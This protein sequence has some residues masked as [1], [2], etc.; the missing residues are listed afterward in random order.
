MNPGRKALTLVHESSHFW[1]SGLSEDFKYGEEGC[2]Q[3]AKDNPDKA[4]ANADNIKFFARN[5]EGLE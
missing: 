2:K 1:D 3:L 5:E 4:I